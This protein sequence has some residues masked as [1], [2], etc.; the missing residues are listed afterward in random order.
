MKLT[1]NSLFHET[2]QDYKQFCGRHLGF[3]WAAYFNGCNGRGNTTLLLMAM[4]PLTRH[5]SRWFPCFTKH[6][7]PT[8]R[9]GAIRIYY[10]L[11]D[12]AQKNPFL[13]VEGLSDITL[14]DPFEP[15]E[16]WRFKNG[17]PEELLMLELADNF[18]PLS[19]RALFLKRSFAAKSPSK[20]LSAIH[21]LDLLYRLFQSISAL[22]AFSD[23]FWVCFSPKVQ[24]GQAGSYLWISG[25]ILSK[26]SAW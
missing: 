11:L 18:D 20:S 3:E 12:F 24:T 19:R 6:N 14:E 16:K 4:F 2:F 5:R 25:V 21:F 7:F 1:D 8:W 23:N 10:T 22:S 26:Q 13:L 17:F 9:G 15:K